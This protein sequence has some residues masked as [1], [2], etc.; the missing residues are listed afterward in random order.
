MSMASGIRE[1][2]I[3]RKEGEGDRRVPLA[4]VLERVSQGWKV[5]SADVARDFLGRWRT[6]FRCP[7]E[8][9]ETRDSALRFDSDLGNIRLRGTSES[10][11]LLIA[12]RDDAQEIV[13]AFWAKAKPKFS[14]LKP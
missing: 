4:S 8:V 2:P 1:E 3:P 12:A 5:G 10:H 6:A 14:L 9:K 7:T 11:C 13:E